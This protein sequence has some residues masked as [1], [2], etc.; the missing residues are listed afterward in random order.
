M[1]ADY[2]S[3]LSS[4]CG[5][6]WKKVGARRRAGVTT[7]L[8]SLYS[9]KSVGIGEAPDLKLLIDWCKKTG[10]SII[11]LLPLNDV[12]FDF[13]PYDAQSSMALDPMYLSLEELEDCNL[14][15]FSKDIQELRK[16]F[17]TGK[18]R[19][20]YGIKKAKLELLEKIFASG[21]SSKRGK[22]F[23]N[24]LREN[25]SWLEDYAI[26]KTLKDEFQMS[27]WMDWPEG[28]R[29]KQPHAVAEVVWK[30][31]DRILFYK[32]LQWQLFEQFKDVKKYATRC[33]VLLMGDMPF[34]VARD[35]ADVWAHQEY[36]KLDLSSGAPSDLYFAQGQRWGMPPYNWGR[37]AADDFQYVR[38]KMKCAENLFDLY[39][40]DHFVGMFRLWTIPLSEPM[41]HAGLYGS[42][43]PRD[44]Q[45]WKDH[46]QKILEVM[47]ESAKM[48]PCAEDLGVVPKCSYEILEEYKIPG[49]DVQRWVRNWGKDFRFKAGDRYRENSMAMLSTHDTS[50]FC[51]WW[52]NEAGTVDEW[53]F[54]KK[55][56]ESGISFDH[57]KEKLFD[58]HHSKHGR[59]RWRHEIESVGMLLAILGKSR[60]EAWHIV[61]AYQSSYEE[62]KFYWQHVGMTGPVEPRASRE[63]V[64]KALESVNHTR[65]IFS[66]QILQDWLSLGEFAERDSWEYRINVPGSMGEKNWS[67]VAPFSLEAMQEFPANKVIH[68]IVVDSGRQVPVK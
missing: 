34:L 55:C 60:D 23:L 62:R 47:L 36:F 50:A 53:F 57:F 64:R 33:G 26:F 5:K 19:V 7:P 66:L 67:V 40:I 21:T 24:F 22:Q 46:G 25:Q 68:T 59:L 39:R 6:I 32:W 2:A 11:Q 37:I 15:D 17:P 14:R 52:E 27:S 48:L 44:E 10:L 18:A 1:Q 65:S 3:F 35:S 63:F 31:K 49:S 29:A 61:D 43:D 16:K 41:E 54:C 51:A 12:G 13:R 38:R 9:S 8:F 56:G 45:L 4:Q 42:F 30:N 28:L 20:N 58:L